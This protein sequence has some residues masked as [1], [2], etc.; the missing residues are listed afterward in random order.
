MDDQN[1][2]H[3]EWLMRHP[4]AALSWSHEIIA[5]RGR[6]DLDA[7][8]MEIALS[9]LVSTPSGPEE[10]SKD[11]W[12]ALHRGRMDI[13]SNKLLAPKFRDALCDCFEREASW[14]K[15]EFHL[16]GVGAW[17]HFFENEADY[18]VDGETL[19]AVAQRA[20]GSPAMK[21]FLNSLPDERLAELFRLNARS[22]GMR[23]SAWRLELAGRLSA[24]A[25]CNLLK[26]TCFST[27]GMKLSNPLNGIDSDS[28]RLMARSAL[29]DPTMAYDLVRCA[30]FSDSAERA[31]GAD[32]LAVLLGEFASNPGMP[33][34]NPAGAVEKVFRGSHG[35]LSL[36]MQMI[37]KNRP[38]A[39]LAAAR[40]AVALGGKGRAPQEARSDGI[41]TTKFKM[42]VSPFQSHYLSSIPVVSLGEAALVLCD[43]ET[44]LKFSALG[45][46]QPKK[47]RAQ[48]LASKVSSI[49]VALPSKVREELLARGKNVKNQGAEMMALWEEAQLMRMLSRAKP[50]SQEGQAS[51]AK[52]SA[53]RM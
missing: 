40:W 7:S 46:P 28:V 15:T 4:L 16:V 30:L 26:K 22:I 25:S 5:G 9:C 20:I 27:G 33:M 53:L 24:V 29:A 44:M 6:A 18:G 23:A 19:E 51:P 21:M 43:K 35:P 13:L 41:K 1:K 34:E 32:S 2:K 37:C 12:G 8:E 17:L 36:A 3:A 14:R 47:E 11:E 39:A 38:E 49:V 48:E 31:D 52:K 45:F 50:Q 10:W 42:A